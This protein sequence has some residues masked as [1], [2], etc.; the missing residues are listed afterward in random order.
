MRKED[1]RNTY[2]EKMIRDTVFDLL[3]TKPI[4]KISVTEVCKAADIN[5]STFY[6]HYKDCMH[7]LEVEQ[8][9]F[10]GKLI[11]SIEGVEDGAPLDII[12][13]LHDM[14]REDHDIYLLLLRS[15]QPMQ[16]FP[17]FTDY[18]RRY[19]AEGLQKQCSL[20]YEEC[21]WVSQYIISGSFAI[22]LLFAHET[23]FDLE[24]EEIFHAFTSGGICALAKQYPKVT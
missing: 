6:L 1:R 10:C 4:D 8:E 14:A 24:R 23:E 5:R 17:K 7:V 19:L 22:S 12:S 2:T 13:K 21:D 16:A 9:K 11:A 3:R 20:S 18:C 15:G